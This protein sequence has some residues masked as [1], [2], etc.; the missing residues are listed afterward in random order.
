[1]DMGA[2]Q[3]QW[4]TPPFP[5]QA[6]LSLENTRLAL[7]WLAGASGAFVF[8][9]P[10]PYEI[11]SLLTIAVFAATGLALNARLL[12]LL[13]LLIAINLGYSVSATQVFDQ[14]RTL[15][16]VLVSCYLGATALFYS[17]M[18]GRNAEQ[19]LSAL[20]SGY[21][22]AAVLA[23]T[24]AILGYF[25]LFGGA[26]DFF[27][28]YE[29]ARGTFNDPNV[30][31]AFLVLPVLLTYQRILAGKARQ[32]VP[33][34]AILCVLAAALLLTFS[35]GAWAQCAIALALLTSLM[36][37]TSSSARERARITAA[38]LLGL[39]ALAGLILA[40]LSVDRVAELFEMRANL[41][42]SYDLGH[43][44]RF[45]RHELGFAL[46]LEKPL[47]VGPLQFSRY[48]PED[49]HNSYLNAFMSGGWLSGA[50]YLALVLITLVYGL[51]HAF[52]PAPLQRIYL[53]LFS[54]YAAAAVES[55]IIDT[56]HW[57]HYFL[58][59]GAVWGLIAASKGASPTGR[60]SEARARPSRSCA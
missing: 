12:P 4:R 47:G 23:S 57:R 59:L 44:G 38:A 11:A 31:G 28:R 49:P 16:W 36:F 30:L 50:S 29:R 39:V 46:A 34:A 18:L 21:M 45:G 48:F 40:L 19:R 10:S 32:F 17:A 43:T 55:A 37:V 52:V 15:M 42:Q 6:G 35:R 53:A 27:L 33:Q 13:F 14:E 54:A 51:R 2:P 7:L 20:L 26:S 25:H 24:L 1:M 56:D 41:D 9:E 22:F 58:L 60:T 8:M 5:A 3:S